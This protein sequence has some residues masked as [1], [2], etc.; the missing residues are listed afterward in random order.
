MPIVET[1]ETCDSKSFYT[2]QSKRKKINLQAF[3][4]EWYFL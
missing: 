2:E 4:K 3:K 1:E